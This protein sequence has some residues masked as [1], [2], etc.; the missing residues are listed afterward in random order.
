MDAAGKSTSTCSKAD[1]HYFT[2]VSIRTVYNALTYTR[3]QTVVYA[4]HVTHTRLM[5]KCHCFGSS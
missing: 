4:E 1:M 3:T 2:I 5:C